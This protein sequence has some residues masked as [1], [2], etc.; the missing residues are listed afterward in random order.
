MGASLAKLIEISRLLGVHIEGMFAADPETCGFMFSWK[1]V[2]DVVWQQFPF[3]DM[4]K[5]K[6]FTVPRGGDPIEKLR[7]YFLTA[8]GPQFTTVFHRKKMH[9][10]NV[11]NEYALLA[12]QARVLDR[13]RKASQSGTR[14]PHSNSMIV[15]LAKLVDSDPSKGR[16]PSRASSPRGEGHRTNHRRSICPAPF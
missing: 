14:F 10:G 13:A 12:W 9:S 11:P 16:T 2:E 5:R 15:G 6:W 4:I 3:R 1:T 8:A 7:E